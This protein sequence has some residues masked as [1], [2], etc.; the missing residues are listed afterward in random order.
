[1]GKGNPELSIV[2]ISLNEEEN[3]GKLLT[4][5]KK[6]DYKNYELILSDAGSTDNTKKIAR[7]FRCKI[8]KGGLPAR[9]RNNGARVAR[10]KFILFL[11]SDVILPQGFLK[12]VIKQIKE[13]KIDVA[14]VNNEPITKDASEILFHDIYNLW[15]KIM[16][17]IDPHAVGTCILIKKKVFRKIGGFDER[18]KLAEDH[19]L[20]R[21]A[22][23]NGAKFRVL[24]DKI[25]VSTRRLKNDGK[26]N[27]AVKFILATLHRIFIGEIRHDGFKYN[28][29]R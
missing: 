23:R 15:Q 20:A 27:I 5:I 1:M 6:Q 2:I 29:K 17:K 7:K 24:D 13:K 22:F 16:Q 3:I 9:G 10:G 14:T 21:K 11:D 25:L 19:A 12:S 8:V 28:L 26:V 18:I 4:S